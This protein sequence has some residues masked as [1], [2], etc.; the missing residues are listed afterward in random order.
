MIDVG[1]GQ[2]IEPP[3]LPDRQKL[4]QDG[5]DPVPD[6]LIIRRV[7]GGDRD[8]N[9][10]G[11]GDGG[12][13]E[14]TRYNVPPGQI[15]R[16]LTYL[17]DVSISNGE[18]WIVREGSDTEDDES[19]RTR[20]LRAWSE[21]PGHSDKALCLLCPLPLLGVVRHLQIQPRT[22][23]V[24]DEHI[25]QHHARSAYRS[26][27]WTTPSAC[28]VTSALQE[29]RRPGRSMWSLTQFAWR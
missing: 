8:R 1:A 24:G 7:M 13:H 16:T 2:L 12:L 17:G 25:A 26:F 3:P 11:H 9:I 20:T 28:A 5:L 22:A 27:G 14:G 21:L 15:T 18:D 4:R 23:G 10:L 29:R 6:G 19:A